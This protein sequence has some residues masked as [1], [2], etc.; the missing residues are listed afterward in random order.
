MVVEPSVAIDSIDVSASRAERVIASMF[1]GMEMFVVSATT[2]D[3][4]FRGILSTVRA[5]SVDASSP[6]GEK[7]TWPKASKVR[8]SCRGNART[9]RWESKDPR[10]MRQRS[11]IYGADRHKG[12]FSEHQHG[13]DA[14]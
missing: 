7:S 2:E 9:S 4:D 1:C 8:S 11:R 5:N 3:V 10:G 14:V 12:I 13:V 6:G